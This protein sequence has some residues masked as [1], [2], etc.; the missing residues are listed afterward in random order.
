MTFGLAFPTLLGNPNLKQEDARTYT[1]GAV[2]SSPLQTPWLRRMKLS[3]DYY[4]IDL[5][6]A[7]S[8]QGIDGVYRRCFAKQ[9]NPTYAF[10]QYCALIGRVPA[11]GEVSNVSITYSNAG[12]VKTSGIDG[13]LDWAV[14]LEE[15]GLHAP[16]V[17][18]A[19]VTATYLL[20]FQTTTDDG[21]IPLVDYAGSLGSGQVGTNAGAYRWKVFS[22]FTYAVGPMTASLQWQFKSAVRSLISVTD[23]TSNTTGAPSY[24]LFNLNGTYAVTPAMQLRFGVDNLFDR[25]P[26]LISQNLNATGQGANLKGG[27][28]DSANYDVLGRR[29]FVGASLRF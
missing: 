8:Q 19:N 20:N 15:A 10:N 16:G 17:F 11:T 25:D 27:T 12:R 14:D 2:F 3:V 22:T 5:S 13:Q 18:S 26:P 6:N 23:P 29:F 1:I 7:I 24:H 28:Y 4:N 9:Y 21:I